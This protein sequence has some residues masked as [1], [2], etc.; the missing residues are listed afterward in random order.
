M[1]FL[2]F[3]FASKLE[4]PRYT[5]C[6]HLTWSRG[7]DPVPTCCKNQVWWSFYQAVPETPA[8]V[9]LQILTTWFLL[10]EWELGADADTY[11]Q[12]FQSQY[13]MIF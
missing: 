7:L 11:I 10:S 2:E 1:V 4:Y 3:G 6:Y 5:G 12:L 8:W 13:F 9:C